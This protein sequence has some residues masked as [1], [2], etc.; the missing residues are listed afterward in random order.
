MSTE[1]LH[2][3]VKQIEHIKN[4]ASEQ[5]IDLS[6]E[7]SVLE[8]RLAY[9]EK[10]RLLH[11]E[12][13]ERVRLARHI[14][15]PTTMDYIHL[16]CTDFI[17]IHGDR[18]M[19]D[20]PSLICG[21]AR[22]QG[23][24][25]TV[26][27]H[28]KGKDTKENL[29]RNFGMSQPEGYRK[30]LRAMKQAE[31]FHRPVLTFINTPGAYPGQIAEEHGQSEAIARNLWEMAMLQTPT[32]SVII[33]EG[34][35]GGAL[36][37]GV[38]DKIFILENAW[39]SVIAPESAAAIL[40]KDASQAKQAAEIMK[41]TAFDLQALG[42]VDGVVPE[43]PGGAHTDY[44]QQANNIRVVLEKSLQELKSIPIDRLIQERYVKFQKIK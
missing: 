19:G 16:L 39:Y 41:I 4:F 1:H 8:E 2:E 35:S 17:E 13:M 25:I 33:G 43:P 5:S 37:L 30:A 28:Q 38:T 36:A 12:P 34:G 26:I 23:E 7:I 9:L 32:M 21:I 14:E 40:W 3:L 44:V 6:K 42:V 20:D 15:R 24:P 11:P 18:M 22:F 10:Q 31:K 29:M 27:G